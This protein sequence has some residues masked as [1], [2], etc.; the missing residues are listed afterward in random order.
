M[1]HTKETK[2]KI[3]K[4]T[5]LAM[6]KPEIRKRLSDAKKGKEPWNKNKKGLQVAWNKDKKGLQVAWNR[7]KE[8]LQVRGEKNGNWAGGL[9]PSRRK[10]QTRY[11]MKWLRDKEKEAGRKRPDYCELCKETGRICFDHNHATGEFRGWI[12]HR[13]NTV[14][15]FAKDDPELLEKMSKYLKQQKA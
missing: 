15:G 7:G 11:K 13:C 2:K 8:Y 4:R 6:S 10:R 1:K 3:S 12:C 9:I 14:I 5:K